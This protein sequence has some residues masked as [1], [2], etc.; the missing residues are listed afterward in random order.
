M[1]ANLLYSISATILLYISIHVHGKLVTV[2]LFFNLWTSCFYSLSVSIIRVYP[3]TTDIKGTIVFSM[4]VVDTGFKS[5]S[6][7]ERI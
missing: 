6:N 2:C 1:I 7:T 4:S 3:L 5:E